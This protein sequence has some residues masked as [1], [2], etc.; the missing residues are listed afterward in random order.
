MNLNLGSSFLSAPSLEIITASCCAE[1]AQKTALHPVD[2]LK[3][4][5]Q[6]DPRRRAGNFGPRMVLAELRDAW[7]IVQAEP[8][9]VT[10][11]YRG[12]GPSV[13]GAVPTAAVYMPTYEASKLALAGTPFAPAAGVVTGIVSAAVRVPTSVRKTCSSLPG[14]CYCLLAPSPRNQRLPRGP[15]PRHCLAARCF[16]GVIIPG[17]LRQGLSFSFVGAWFPTHRQVIKAQMQL[18]LHDGKGGAA[19]VVA[20]L[21]RDGIGGL[22]KGLRATV[23]RR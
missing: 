17:S 19:A 22:F 14:P 5:M 7:A 23:E 18:G 1:L 21:Q 10:A 6:Y 8:R 9:P 2:S 15:Q 11:L 20:V 4:R 3:V 12:L 16:N 13:I